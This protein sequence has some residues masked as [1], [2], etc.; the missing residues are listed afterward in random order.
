MRFTV[1]F[2]NLEPTGALKEYA[3]EKLEKVQRFIN[4]EMEAN[5]VFSIEK[6]LH[7]ADITLTSKGVLF[8]GTAKSA[9]MYVS[10]DQA[11]D[12]I[13]LQARKRKERITNRKANFSTRIIEEENYEVEPTPVEELTL[14]ESIPQVIKENRFYSKPMTIE[15]A[16]MQLDQGNEDFLVFSN[17]HSGDIN[18]LFLRPDGNYGVVEARSNP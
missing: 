10:I 9:D 15:E 7:I 6:Y 8:K 5:V 16:I 13:N 11:V 12:K 3:Q 17:A 1:T 14:E 18:V 2:R 4:R